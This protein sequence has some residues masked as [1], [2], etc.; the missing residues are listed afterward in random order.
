MDTSEL[1]WTWIIGYENLYEVS[2]DGVV[3]SWISKHPPS[4]KIP[5]L[6]RDGYLDVQLKHLQS[7][8]QFLVHRLIATHFIPNPHQYPIINHIDGNKLNNRIGNLEWC[9]QSHNVAHGFRVLGRRAPL[10]GAKLSAAQVVELLPKI[11]DCYQSKGSVQRRLSMLGQEYGV[12]RS[13]LENIR[14]GMTWTDL[15]KEFR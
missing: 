2:S 15:T 12:R 3:R 13:A 4:I 6:R 1:K 5:R 9:T 8:R 7:P 11:E 14:K 10:S